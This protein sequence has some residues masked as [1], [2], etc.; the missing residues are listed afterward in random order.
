MVFE[1]VKLSYEK[2]KIE[3]GLKIKIVE[4]IIDKIYIEVI[5]FERIE[6]YF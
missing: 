3:N 6:I 2:D 4:V 1:N 5:C